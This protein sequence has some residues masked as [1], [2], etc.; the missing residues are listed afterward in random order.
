MTDKTREIDHDFTEHD[1]AMA[2]Y[3][4]PVV[5]NAMEDF[6]AMHLSYEQMRELNPI[7]H[8][9]AYTALHALRAHR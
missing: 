3:I 9:A 1:R 2:K 4:A 8:N 6:H 7:I 5:H